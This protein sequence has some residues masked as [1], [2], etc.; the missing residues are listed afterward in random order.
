MIFGNYGPLAREWCKKSALFCEKH[1][2]KSIVKPWMS[3][4]WRRKRRIC[5]MAAI[6][7]WTIL[8]VFSYLFYENDKI[9]EENLFEKLQILHKNQIYS[10][11]CDFSYATSDFCEIWCNIGKYSPLWWIFLTIFHLQ[12]FLQV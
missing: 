3:A 2:R 11:L 4:D 7:K 5:K 9:S 1:S 6:S 12:S 8:C 10:F